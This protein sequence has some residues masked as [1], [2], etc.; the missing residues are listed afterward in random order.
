[1]SS[2][3]LRTDIFSSLALRWCCRKAWSKST[4]NPQPAG[5]PEVADTGSDNAPLTRIRL[6]PR[7]MSKASRRASRGK[8][9]C[10][11]DFSSRARS[12]RS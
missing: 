3:Y 2:T 11:A 10:S 6:R 9:A 7:Y 8:L 5:I 4:A 1:M 12:T